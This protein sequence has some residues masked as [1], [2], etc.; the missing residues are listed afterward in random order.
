MGVY[1]IFR[2]REGGGG[3]CVIYAVCGMARSTVV[4][5]FLGG[6]CEGGKVGKERNKRGRGGRKKEGDGG[7]M[8]ELMTMRR[9]RED[10][11]CDWWGRL[12]RA[13]MAMG[14]GGK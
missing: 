7:G 4:I 10:L 14:W 6:R 5:C 11:G 9:R 8:M 1:V 12:L 2:R 3:G 13:W